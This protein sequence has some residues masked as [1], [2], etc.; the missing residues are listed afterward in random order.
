MSFA[1]YLTDDSTDTERSFT[2]WRL[3]R[4]LIITMNRQTTGMT[5]RTSE[6]VKLEVCNKRIIKSWRKG[7][8]FFY[9]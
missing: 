7:I 2:R 6:L 3:D 4:T 5:T 9:E 8:V 1:T